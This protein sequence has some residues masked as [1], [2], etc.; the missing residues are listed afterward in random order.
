MQ[1]NF[2]KSLAN[3]RSDLALVCRALQVVSWGQLAKHKQ[4]YRLDIVA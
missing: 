2:V 1:H 3:S 4:N